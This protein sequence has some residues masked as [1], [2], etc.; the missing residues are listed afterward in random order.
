MSYIGHFVNISDIRMQFITQCKNIDDDDIINFIIYVLFLTPHSKSYGI[1]SA[2][3]T[4]SHYFNIANASANFHGTS[5]NSVG[6]CHF[7]A[8]HTN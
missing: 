8:T 3:N 5:F 2:L 1:I 6:C 4:L 7:S